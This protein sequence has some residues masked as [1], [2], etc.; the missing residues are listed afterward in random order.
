MLGEELPRLFSAA[1]MSC[2]GDVLEANG[3]LLATLGEGSQVSQIHSQLRGYATV[4]SPE[5]P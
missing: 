1:S 4:G 3:C 5:N 2:M